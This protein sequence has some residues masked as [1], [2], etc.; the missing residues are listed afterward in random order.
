ML[1]SGCGKGKGEERCTD[2]S[3]T[4]SPC[5]GR[6]RGAR[7]GRE[8][9]GRRNPPVLLTGEVM[10]GRAVCIDRLTCV[11]CAD[12]TRLAAC[13]RWFCLGC[14]HARVDART[15]QSLPDTSVSRASGDPCNPAD[16]LPDHSRKSAARSRG[17]VPRDSL[18]FDG[19]KGSKQS[20]LVPLPCCS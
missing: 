5:V 2:T 9:K 20:S 13:C 18:V 10:G 14:M 19:K 12:G 3:A 7:R 16:E 17:E 4:R 15:W 11:N 8:E 1:L 6:H